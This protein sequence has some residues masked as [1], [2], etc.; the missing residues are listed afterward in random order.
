MK[1]PAL[2]EKKS[3]SKVFKETNWTKSS[4]TVGQYIFRRLSLDQSDKEI[5]RIRPRHCQS[6][7]I[8]SSKEIDMYVS[9]YLN[10]VDKR[11]KNQTSK[12]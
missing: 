11:K 1:K 3:K 2:R 9:D 7:L 12:W 5:S 4:K 8:V 10:R 6:Q